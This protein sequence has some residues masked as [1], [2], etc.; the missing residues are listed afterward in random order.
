MLYSPMEKPRAAHDMLVSLNGMEMYCAIHGEGKPIVLLHG[1]TGSGADWD[2]IFKA[3]PRGY[4]WIVP[5]LRG[6]GRSTNPSG[7]FTHRQA[8]ADVIALLDHL[9]VERCKAIGMSTGAKTLLHVATA[10]PERVSAMVLVSGA[11]YFPP[12]AREFMASFDVDRLTEREWKLLRQRHVHG[13]DQIRALYRQGRDFADNE[14]DMHF[15]PQ[16][17]G[18]ITAATLIVHGDRDPIYP[19]AIPLALYRAI[20]RASLWIVPDSGHVPIFGEHAA[21]FARQAIA[22]LRREPG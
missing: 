1:Y 5:D 18:G 8:A 21:Y 9:G 14:D 10:E 15:T 12:S 20:P 22:F 17:L 11:P 4:C 13:D 16:E 7:R 19:I 2:L 3:P 6:H